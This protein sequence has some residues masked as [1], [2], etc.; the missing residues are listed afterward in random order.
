MIPTFQ[1][2]TGR[3]YSEAER[4]RLARLC[5]EAGI[6]LFEDD[7]YRDLVYGP[8]DRTPV[9]GRLRKA[10]WIY[11]GSFSK[12]FAPGLRLGYLAASPE[13]MP[14]LVRLKQ[15][16]DLHSNRLSQ[17]LILR[18]LEDPGCGARLERL[19]ADYRARRDDFES[20]LQRHFP[21]SPTGKCRP[22]ACFFGCACAN[23]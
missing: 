22:G 20:A 17:W 11:Q 8:C 5:D 13:L 10:P 12:S 21:E 19:A 23:G 16:A 1:N 18:Q 4:E 6:P 14:M 3:C 7:P 9:S 2:P 15:A